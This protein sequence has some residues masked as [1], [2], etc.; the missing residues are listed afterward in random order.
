MESAP[1][2]IITLISVASSERRKEL[3]EEDM[4]VLFLSIMFSYAQVVLKIFKND[5]GSFDNTNNKGLVKYG[6]LILR[7][8][9]I[10]CTTLLFVLLSYS[11]Y[12]MVVLVLY[13]TFIFLCYLYFF[14]CT[15]IEENLDK[16]IWDQAAWRTNSNN[17]LYNIREDFYRVRDRIVSS[18]EMVHID[19]LVLFGGDMT[20]L[21]VSVIC[22]PL[23]IPKLVRGPHES[24]ACFFYAGRLP[25]F[26][27]KVGLG[28]Y[29]TYVDDNMLFDN[30]L[31]GT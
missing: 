29:F 7:A 5:E 12:L 18:R 15:R 3:E 23:F 17:Q 14:T 13:I 26:L 11:N 21:F 24:L 4:Y 16:I 25:F 31:G 19:R 28:H 1:Q 10:L 30:A 8:L 6:R 27:A 20:N 2:M 22:H 9:E